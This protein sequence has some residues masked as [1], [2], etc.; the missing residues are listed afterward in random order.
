MVQA[1]EETTMMSMSDREAIASLEFG[2]SLKGCLSSSNLMGLENAITKRISRRVSFGKLDIREYERAIGDNVVTSGVPISLGW[3]YERETSLDLDNYEQL[4]PAPRSHSEMQLPGHVR[5]ELL[6]H[7]GYSLADRM[8]A[9]KAS[10]IERNRRRA[11]AAKTPEMDRA[12]F[13]LEQ[14]KRKA[15]RVLRRKRKENEKK[16][17][18]ALIQRDRMRSTNRRQLH[19]ADSCPTLNLMVYDGSEVF[20]AAR[21]S[22][23]P[24]KEGSNPTD[25]TRTAGTAATTPTDDEESNSLDDDSEGAPEF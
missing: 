17:I 11:S 8:K 25:S 24:V 2:P 10:N 9:A 5:M 23:E 4:K 15:S 3:E 14:A 16:E 12:E 1:A 13:A 7:A 21:S 20:E 19:R 18:V 22:Q 6:K